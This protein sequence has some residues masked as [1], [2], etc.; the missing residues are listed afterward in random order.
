MEGEKEWDIDRKMAQMRERETE[1]ELEACWDPNTNADSL[2]SYTMCE[3]VCSPV[4]FV[5]CVCHGAS[6]SDMA[7]TSQLLSVCDYRGRFWM[8]YHWALNSKLQTHTH[9]QTRTPNSNSANLPHT[10]PTCPASLWTIFHIK[11]S[12]RLSTDACLHTC[13]YE[14][15]HSC[16]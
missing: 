3:C 15:I 13:P 1:D 11:A 4:F 16:E 8:I 5:K 14:H 12:L 6:D 10:E 9:T 2:A 7:H